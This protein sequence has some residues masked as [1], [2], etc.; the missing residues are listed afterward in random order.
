MFANSAIVVFGTSKV[1]CQWIVK[2]N[3]LHYEFLSFCGHTTLFAL[4]LV[5]NPE[6]SFSC[7]AA[8]LN[9]TMR[10]PVLMQTTKKQIRL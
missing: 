5:G 6:E 3:V 10:K 4:D 9:Y 1:K 8:R 7:D 2:T